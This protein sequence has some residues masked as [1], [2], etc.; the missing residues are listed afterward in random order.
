MRSLHLYVSGKEINDAK[1]RTRELQGQAET[2]ARKFGA[3]IEKL[4]EAVR[5]DDD[6]PPDH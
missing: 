3:M 4:L 2:V 1:R 5:H 6:R